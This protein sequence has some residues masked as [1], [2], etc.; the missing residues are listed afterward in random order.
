MNTAGAATKPINRGYDPRALAVAQRALE[1]AGAERVILFGSRSRGDWRDDSDVDVMVIHPDA[2]DVSSRKPVCDAALGF[3]KE[4]LG[5]DVEVDLVFVTPDKYR[6]R[7]RS[8]NDVAA[9]AHREGIVM[10]ADAELCNDAEREPD[11][12]H[13]N[14]VRYLRIHDANAHYGAMHA[15]LDANLPPEIAIQHAHVTLEHGLK[16]LL[17]AQGRRYQHVIDLIALLAAVN[18]GRPEPPLALGSDL[19]KLNDYAGRFRYEPAEDPI[20]DL[21]DMA[22]NVTDDIAQIYR[23]IANLTGEHPLSGPPPGE[24]TAG[25]RLRYR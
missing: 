5:P 24:N 1:A 15:M 2:A 18:R 9:I 8:V 6:H 25:I 21:D 23:R 17:S 4:R 19:A 11:T 12:A 3:A 14:E 13:E 7:I 10:P 16:A 20:T 22:N